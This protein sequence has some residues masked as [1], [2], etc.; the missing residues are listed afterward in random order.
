MTQLQQLR[1]FLSS[2][3]P[4]SYLPQETACNLF[5]DPD[6]IPDTRLYTALIEQGFRR[7]GEHLYRPHCPKCQACLSIRIPVAHFQPNRQQRRTWNKNQ[8]LEFAATQTPD[9]A[10][11]SELFSRYL[12]SR[13]PGG[14]MDQMDTD[15]QF[16]FLTSDWSETWFYEFREAD[17]LVAVAVTDRLTNGLSAIYSYFSP[18]DAVWR[19]LGVYMVL[20]QI[21]QARQLDL[22]WVYLGFWIAGSPRMAY[23]SNY[24]PAEALKDNQ[25]QKFQHLV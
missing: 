22:S 7:S 13:H 8:D 3:H 6:V 21:H 19:S 5:L 25:W 15:T 16:A 24:Q 10:A 9:R 18:E 14:G 20:W 23:K 17:R 4:C 2:P 12:K 11:H 1:L